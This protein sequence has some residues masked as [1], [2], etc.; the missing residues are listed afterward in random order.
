MKPSFNG[1]STQKLTLEVTVSNHEVWPSHLTKAT[2][3]SLNTNIQFI[4][5]IYPGISNLMAAHMISIARREY[6]SEWRMKIHS[7]KSESENGEMPAPLRGEPVEPLRVRYTYYTAGSGGVGPTILE[8]SFL[9]AGT[10]VVVYRDG[11]KVSTKCRRDGPNTITSF[12]S[13]LGRILTC[14]LRRELKWKVVWVHVDVVMSYNL[15]EGMPMCLEFGFPEDWVRFVDV[16]R[17]LYLHTFFSYQLCASTFAYFKA[18]FVT[19][20]CCLS[21]SYFSF[22]IANLVWHK[23]ECLY[24]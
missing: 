14:A 13:C 5:G 8:T 2:W 4:L 17:K 15:E 3:I 16:I 1:I 24:S 10:D 7:G 22:R 6:D 19:S 20:Y 21:W 11:K 9:L 23:G 12:M 18:S